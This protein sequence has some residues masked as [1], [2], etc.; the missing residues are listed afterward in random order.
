MSA[1]LKVPAIPAPACT[2]PIALNRV[3]MRSARGLRR[4]RRWKF[5]ARRGGEQTERRAGREEPNPIVLDE[6]EP[7]ALARIEPSL[8]PVSPEF[9]DWRFLREVEPL[10]V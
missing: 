7:R 6:E 8:L 10:R 2:N 3:T 1:N 9:L 4:W 5:L